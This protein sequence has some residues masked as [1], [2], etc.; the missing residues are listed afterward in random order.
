MIKKLVKRI[1]TKIVVGHLPL[2]L[3]RNSYQITSN[4]TSCKDI[5]SNLAN[6]YCNMN[7]DDQSPVYRELDARDYGGR[8]NTG[9]SKKLELF[10]EQNPDVAIT[11]FV[12]PNFK[13]S[14]KQF[15]DK[16]I[17]TNPEYSEW[18]SYLVI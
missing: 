17:L 15:K 6:V 2:L 16:F 10:L 4:V 9:I 7:F 5:L 1:I 13:G 8:I 14:T 12:I 18:I 3:V 11:S